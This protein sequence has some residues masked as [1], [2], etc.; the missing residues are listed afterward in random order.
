MPK[1]IDSAPVLLVSDVAASANYLG[2]NVAKVDFSAKRGCF[3][4]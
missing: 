1:I 4:C 3:G 2:L